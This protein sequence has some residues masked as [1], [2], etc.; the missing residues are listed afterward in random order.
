MASVIDNPGA[1]IGLTDEQTRDFDWYECYPA[2]GADGTCVAV[3]DACGV[4]NAPEDGE[5]QGTPAAVL[6][7]TPGDVRFDDQRNGYYPVQR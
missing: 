6:A 4:Y 5:F 3:I 7:G 1:M 2:F